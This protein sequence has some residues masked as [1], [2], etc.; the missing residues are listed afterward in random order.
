MCRDGITTVGWDIKEAEPRR[1][2]PRIPMG[3][4]RWPAK[5]EVLVET[6]DAAETTIRLNGKIGGIGPIQKNYLRGQMN[7]LRNA[8]E[9]AAHKTA[10]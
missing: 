5:I 4:A 7:R 6:G 3:L 1:I 10:G 2:V 9:V 8:I